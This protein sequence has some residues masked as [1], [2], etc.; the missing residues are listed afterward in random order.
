MTEADERKLLKQVL[1]VPE[2][3][4]PRKWYWQAVSVDALSFCI[5]LAIGL[6]LLNSPGLLDAPHVLALVGAVLAGALIGALSTWKLQC[7]NS[8]YVRRYIDE[9]KVRAR[10]SELDG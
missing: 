7:K 2:E 3:N 5:L 6:W 8:D 10:L 1:L 4:A 9:Q